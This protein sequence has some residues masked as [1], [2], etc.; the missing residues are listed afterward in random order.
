MASY[1][2]LIRF[3]N[4]LLLVL[5]QAMLCGGL[6]VPPQEWSWSV[7]ALFLGTACVAGR[8]YML[9]D[10]F[11][12]PTDRLNRP[13]RPLVRGVISSM[14][15]WIL[16]ITLGVLAVGAALKVPAP[17]WQ[18][19]IIADILLVFYAR[20]SKQMS[21]GANLMV[22][23]LSGW[24]LMLV[25]ALTGTFQVALYLV[26]GTATLLHLVRELVKDLEDMEGDR[27][28]NAVTLPLQ[29]GV[30]RTVGL[31]QGLM[32]VLLAV[33]GGLSIVFDSLPARSLLLLMGIQV[34][35]LCYYLWKNRQQAHFSRL[36]AWLKALMFEG[37]FLALL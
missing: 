28:I 22:A 33:I 19:W 37:L 35:G 5:A 16:H 1:L 26:A 20:Y 9:N 25:G 30:A 2:K 11:D 3:P 17:V 32:L 8:G 36:S 18:S 24:S 10:W 6:Y 7:Y 12:V 27:F 34:L 4:L 23:G 15:F 31:V 29:W 21:I 13:E 14:A